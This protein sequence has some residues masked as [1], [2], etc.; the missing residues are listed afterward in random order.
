MSHVPLNQN[1]LRNLGVSPID[2]AR[3]RARLQSAPFSKVSPE[4]YLNALVQR[5]RMPAASIGGGSASSSGV[6]GVSGVPL[7]EG[8]AGARI[9]AAGSTR[10]NIGNSTGVWFPMGPYKRQPAGAVDQGSLPVAGRVNGIGYAN[11]TT[12]IFYLA[13]ASGGVW[14]WDPNNADGLNSTNKTVDDKWTHFSDTQFATPETSCVA[15][16]PNDHRI[17]YVGMGDYDGS[18]FNGADKEQS[19]GPTYGVGYGLGIMKTVNGGATWYNIAN[20]NP[21]ATAP[22]FTG[23]ASATS[24]LE[25]TAVSAIVINPLNSKNIIATSGRG[26]NAGG[27]W[28]STD[29]G[30]TWTRAS[31]SGGSTIT[32]GNW[33]SLS[34]SN[35]DG[36]ARNQMFYATLEDS[37][38]YSSPDG[39][40]W[41]KLPVP[42]VYNGANNGEGVVGIKIVASKLPRLNNL[43]SIQRVLYVVDA[44]ETKNDGRIFKSID[45]GATWSDITGT[46]PA[47][48]GEVNTFSLASF[49]LNASSSLIPSRGDSSSNSTLRTLLVDLLAVGSRN[50]AT[51]TSPIEPTGAAGPKYLGSITGL[52]ASQVPDP[53]ASPNFAFPT[54]FYF[55]SVDMTFPQGEPPA[56]IPH[57]NTHDYQVSPTSLKAYQNGT[58]VDLDALMASDG[59]IYQSQII[60]GIYG[61]DSALNFLFYQSPDTRIFDPA[62]FDSAG[63]LLSVDATINDNLV[64]SQM[65]SGDFF[66][67]SNTN[68]ISIRSSTVDNTIATTD[69]ALT[70]L[71]GQYPTAY[72]PDWLSIDNLPTD[73]TG[74]PSWA[75]VSYMVNPTVETGDDQAN[76][77]YTT[78]LYTQN[79]MYSTDVDFVGDG[80]EPSIDISG[81]PTMDTIAISPFDPTGAT[82]V[83]LTSST[84]TNGKWN[85]GNPAKKIYYTNDNWAAVR[86]DINF[87]SLDITP[88]QQENI[89]K[90][91]ATIFLYN[92][93]DPQDGVTGPTWQGNYRTELGMPVAWELAPTVTQDL[94]FWQGIGNFTS[95]H[96]VSVSFTGGATPALY[97]GDGQY[98]W[99]FD[100]PGNGAYPQQ[101]APQPLQPVVP[102]YPG[103]APK[104]TVYWPFTAGPNQ[105]RGIWRQMGT[106]ALAGNS[107]ADHISAIGLVPGTGTVYVGTTRRRYLGLYRRQ[108]ASRRGLSIERPSISKCRAMSRH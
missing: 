80:V 48:S 89:G 6:S 12:G 64:V 47:E 50:F 76:D 30:I 58:Q 97:V 68:T 65:L 7:R 102:P 1:R 16:D 69:D 88:D 100:P 39:I 14:K 41:T 46:Y 51:S 53:G 17:A 79:T 44:S 103:V 20:G 75:L 36:T 70:P 24:I 11:D 23:T 105:D 45:G 56:L 34:V 3:Y 52:T 95:Q 29:S 77:F 98:L 5:Q 40:T 67:N 60:N 49:S 83:M 107:A 38:A 25:G 2:V 18:G 90:N 93:T 106:Q 54:D 9:A 19:Q 74:F 43:T 57:K 104:H 42:L 61:L 66:L 101:P 92:T 35:I 84:N 62:T 87:G 91:G 96:D 33:S 37:G 8:T 72:Q 81:Y 4:S 82:Q 86:P 26:V 28:Y 78:F 108:R 27:I 73:G 32:S 22:G 13:T 21:L 55:P 59:G 31:I 15:V 85:D 71:V 63:D 10:I 99:R 94:P